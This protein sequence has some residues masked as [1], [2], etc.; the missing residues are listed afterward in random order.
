MS[1]VE[2]MRVAQ[3]IAEQVEANR[4]ARGHEA[5]FSGH[6]ARL[7]RELSD[8]APAGGA[9]RL[10]LLGAGNAN[11][12]DLAALAA[13]FAEVHLVDID[14][15]AVEEARARLPPDLRPRVVAHAPVDVSGLHD[16]LA[17]WAT[18]PT[19]PAASALAAEVPAAVERVRAALPGPFDV[20]ASCCL[21][22]QL[23]L[24]LLQVVGDRHLRFPELRAL[25]NAVHVR[26]LAGLLGP[27]GVGLLVTEMTS[28]KT[29]P[30]GDLPPG[31][32]LRRVMD[33]LLHAGNLIAAAHPGL[34]SSE[35]RRDPALKQRYAVRS[36]VGPWLWQNGPSLTFLVYALELR[37]T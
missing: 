13:V 32:D 29:Y 36:P 2:S 3:A 37:N 34:L 15:R 12:V 8:R 35:I 26:V 28:S 6:R 17:G 31:A 1:E 18:A 11:D 22:T 10:A 16:R 20:A 4:S 5:S 30:L 9:G 21:L 24:V 14:A 23:Q 27:G 19:P 7:T 25:V 33:D